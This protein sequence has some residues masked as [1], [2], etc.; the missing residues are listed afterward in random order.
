MKKFLVLIAALL[1]GFHARADNT[2][3]VTL[4]QMPAPAQEFIKN[5]FAEKTLTFAVLEKGFLEKEYKILF[6]DG[7]TIEFDSKG[8]WKDIEC[9][10]GDTVP[11]EAVPVQIAQ[12][13]TKTYP[14]AKVYEIDRDNR[15]YDV[16]LTNRM[17]LEFNTDF[18][19]IDMDYDD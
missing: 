6:T 15:G 1:V 8:N 2:V 13:I 5:H 17:E 7:T 10:R 18:T 3:P 11:W 16:K 14:D 9:K 4:E 12:Y 19:V